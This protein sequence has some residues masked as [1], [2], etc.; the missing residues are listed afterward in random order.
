MEW[1]G[2]YLLLLSLTGAVAVCYDKYAA[3]H[4]KGRVSERFLF[5]LAMLG[6][7]A[8]VYVTMLLIRH[9][10]CHKRFMLGL[11]ALLFLQLTALR[12]VFKTL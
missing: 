3:R 8:G 5:V 4:R 12:W 2:G 9:K 11:P 6:G 1:L 7:S 10:T